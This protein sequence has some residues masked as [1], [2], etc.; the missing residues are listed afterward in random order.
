MFLGTL[1]GTVQSG[2]TPNLL[3]PANAVAFWCVDDQEAFNGGGQR[4]GIANMTLLSG[5][6]CKHNAL[7]RVV[8]GYAFV[9]PL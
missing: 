8:R 3:N 7:A 9:V 4:S 5:V 1:T 6:D 2:T